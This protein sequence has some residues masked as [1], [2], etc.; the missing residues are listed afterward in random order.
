MPFDDCESLFSRVEAEPFSCDAVVVSEAMPARRNSVS[1]STIAD[2]AADGAGGGGGGGQGGGV[3]GAARLLQRLEALYAK[4]GV[5]PPLLV[6]VVD[7]GLDGSNVGNRAAYAGLVPPTQQGESSVSGGNIYGATA[8]AAAPAQPPGIRKNG[9]SGM[10]GADPHTGSTSSADAGPLGSPKTAA[11]GGSS[12]GSGGGAGGAEDAA[13]TAAA[14]TGGGGRL[15]PPSHTDS[16]LS[17]GSAGGV[18][19]I[20][21]I[22]GGRQLLPQ[23]RLSLGNNPAGGCLTLVRPVTMEAVQTIIQIAWSRRHGVRVSTQSAEGLGGAE[24]V[25]SAAPYTSSVFPASSVVIPGW[26][27]SPLPPPQPPLRHGIGGGSAESLDELA[28]REQQATPASPRKMLGIEEASS[29]GPDRSDA[30][31]FAARHADGGGGHG[32][33]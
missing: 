17:T 3:A 31:A 21:G 25:I 14:T 7:R 18:G 32:G 22:A 26:Q 20:G 27:Q 6:S 24:S 2:S 1:T 4:L 30:T 23:A 19:G 13:H 15:P 29:S 33:N 16:S 8:A 9:S 5:T 12:A 11:A 10:F 28:D